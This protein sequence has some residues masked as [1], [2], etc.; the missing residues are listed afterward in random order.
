M[1]EMPKLRWVDVNAA[2]VKKNGITNWKHCKEM[3][4]ERYDTLDIVRIV[5]L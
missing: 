1:G 3:S 2:V 5:A 4:V